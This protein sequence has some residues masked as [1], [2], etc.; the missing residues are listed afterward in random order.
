MVGLRL[1][2]HIALTFLLNPH[3]YFYLL[4][5][6]RNKTVRS[7]LSKDQ[8]IKERISISKYLFNQPHRLDE[9]C[10]LTYIYNIIW[11]NTFI[12]SFFNNYSLSGGGFI[13]K[14]VKYGL[15]EVF[16]RGILTELCLLIY[17]EINKQILEF[18]FFS[19]SKLPFLTF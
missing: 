17:N 2:C 15:L 11:H 18:R 14:D 9:G 5:T 1:Y 13:W 7:T 8:L 12:I 6:F 16:E 4:G 19:I 3:L 10:K